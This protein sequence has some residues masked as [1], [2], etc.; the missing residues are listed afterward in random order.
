METLPNGSSM[1]FPMDD[2]SFVYTTHPHPR[3]APQV[4]TAPPNITDNALSLLSVTKAL[5]I[6]GSTFMIPQ[7][8]HVTS[9]PQNNDH[10]LDQTVKAIYSSSVPTQTK[11]L[12]LSS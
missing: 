12:A 8:E 2:S 7:L 5:K 4:T 6:D 3:F 1:P 10:C 9:P 11:Y